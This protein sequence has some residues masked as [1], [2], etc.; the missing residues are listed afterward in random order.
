MKRNIIRE[1]KYYR[2]GLNG[3]FELYVDCALGETA[4]FLLTLYG[5]VV[6]QTYRGIEDAVADFYA[7]Q[8]VCEGDDSTLIV[9]S[10]TEDEILALGYWVDSVYKDSSREY[11]LLDN[12]RWDSPFLVTCNGCFLFETFEELKTALEKWYGGDR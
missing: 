6:G 5:K 9:G 1:R 4:P 2:V 8:R 7:S 12:G 10:T 11:K 3:G